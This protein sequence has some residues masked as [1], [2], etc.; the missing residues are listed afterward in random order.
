[1]NTYKKIR[2]HNL[3]NPIFTDV[4]KYRETVTRLPV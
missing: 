4:M 1:M 3:L 2:E